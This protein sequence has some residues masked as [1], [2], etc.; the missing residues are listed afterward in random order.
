[1]EQF[2]PSDLAVNAKMREEMRYKPG[3]VEDPT[4][5]I[6]TFQEI[7]TNALEKHGDEALTRENYHK[8][9]EHARRD[10]RWEHLHSGASTIESHIK[11][12]LGIK[13]D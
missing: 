4:H 10:P 13:D 9:M 6:N 11:T 8:V 12:H 5:R 1:M 7:V 2:H 3:I